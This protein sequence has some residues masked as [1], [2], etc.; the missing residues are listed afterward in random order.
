MIFDKLMVTLKF[1]L[2]LFF[3]NEGATGFERIP[4]WF[5]W[6][7][8]EVRCEIERGE[9]TPHPSAGDKIEENVKNKNS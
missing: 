3:A 7:R 2:D 9:D 8:H 4:D 1:V 5:K 6:E